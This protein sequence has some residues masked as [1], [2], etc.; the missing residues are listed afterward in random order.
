MN[1]EKEEFSEGEVIVRLTIEQAVRKGYKDV[2]FTWHGLGDNI[3]M[4]FAAET[5]FKTKGKKLLISTNLPDLLDN[6]DYCDFIDNINTSDFP[7][8][9]K[10]F[11]KQA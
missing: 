1:L 11:K 3:V 6:S 5:Y 4:F 7:S 10:F 2:Y 9:I 8:V